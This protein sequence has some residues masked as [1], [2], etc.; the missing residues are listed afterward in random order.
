MNSTSASASPSSRRARGGG[1][2]RRA[3][4]I[5]LAPALLFAAL[6]APPAR[7]KVFYTQQEALA[8][9]FPDADDVAPRN[10][11][12]TD[13]QARRIEELSRSQLDTRLVRI[14]RGMKGEAILGYVF[15]EVHT[16]RTQ[17]EA[18]MVVL[19]PEGSVQT[20]RMLAFHEP[21]DY[22]PPDRWVAQF[23]HKTKDDPLRV[24]GDIHG[25]VGA[26]LSARATTDGVRR[27]L[28]IYQV[29]LAGER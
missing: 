21:L 8:L 19:T 2:G 13:E 26:T 12:L 14:W 28:A 20:V 25:I 27:A 18:F 15:I 22:L 3:A 7:A 24:G 16:V 1:C 5:A 23:E 6:G 29:L 10:W 17:A 9:A 4:R 11:V